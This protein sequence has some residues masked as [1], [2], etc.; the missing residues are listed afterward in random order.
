MKNG[1]KKV[2][3]ARPGGF[4]MTHYHSTAF[5]DLMAERNAD[6]K[7]MLADKGY[8]SD[9]IRNEV[10]ARGVTPEIPI[11]KNRHVQ[12]TVNRAL[13]ATRNRMIVSVMCGRPLCRKG[14]ST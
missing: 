2:L 11:K 3:S 4:K 12:Y 7:V 14:N 1:L 10:R 8:D 6:P 5:T 13:Y 9:A